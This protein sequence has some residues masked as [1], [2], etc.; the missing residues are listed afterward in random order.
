MIKVNT[1]LNKAVIACV[2][3]MIKLLINVNILN[4]R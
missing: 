2:I 1:C 4:Y 3:K